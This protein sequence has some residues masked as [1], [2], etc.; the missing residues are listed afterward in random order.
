MHAGTTNPSPLERYA[1]KLENGVKAQSQNVALIKEEMKDINDRISEAKS[2]QLPGS[3]TVF[4][5]C[6]LKLGHTVRNST[7]ETCSNVF[8]CG[9]KKFHTHQVNRAKLN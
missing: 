5:N 8:D 9:F 6:H 3:L 4:G 1:S 7:M 2:S